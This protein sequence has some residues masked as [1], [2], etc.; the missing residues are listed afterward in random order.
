MFTK[1]LNYKKLLDNFLNF[2]RACGYKYKSEE[3][4]LKAFYIYTQEN[5]KSVLGLSKEFLETWSILGI[6]EGRKS[7]SNRVSVIREFG[8][9]LNTLEYKVHV[10]KPLK[11]STNKSFIPYVFSKEEIEKIFLVID[12]LENSNRNRYNS[13]EV[14]PVLLR[15]LYGC[16]L[17][18]SEALN[19][20]IKNVD[21]QSGKLLIDVAKYNKQRIVIM[22]DSLKEICK[23]Y[24]SKYLSTKEAETTF[25]QHK[26]GTLR[27][28]CQVNNFF[29]QLLYK[30]NIPYLGRGK[31]PYLHNLRHTF[32]CHSFYQMHTNGIDMNVGI[33]LLSTYLGHESIKAT[34]RYL[35]LSQEIFPELM[36]NINLCNSNIYT[37]I[38]Y[39]Q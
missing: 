18:I 6:R 37:E 35:K 14:Y 16:G 17:R 36:S 33:F 34:E 25:F 24:K 4:I 20:K 5:K 7:L 21:I 22:S 3:T 2:K 26:D 38:D 30:A 13:H 9:Y 28:R 19:L 15:L 32:A 1:N 29:K 8:I 27:S 31:G 10:L 12:N 11:N 23:E 39:E